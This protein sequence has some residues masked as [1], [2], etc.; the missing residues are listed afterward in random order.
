MY[1][2]VSLAVYK[3]ADARQGNPCLG[4]GLGFGGLGHGCK[5]VRCRAG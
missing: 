2:A 3:A 5:M 1:T 4:L